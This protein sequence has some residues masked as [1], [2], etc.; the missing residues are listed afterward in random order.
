MGEFTYLG[1]KISNTTHEYVEKNEQLLLS[2]LVVKCTAWRSLPLTPVGSVNLLKMV[3]LPKFLY[4]FH[5][6][7]SQIHRSFFRRLE[8]VLTTFIW[9]GRPPRVAKKILYLPL[10]GGCLA[11]QNFFLYYWAAVLVTVRWWF[12]QP[13]QNSAVIL[14]SYAALTNLVYR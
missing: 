7:A 14:G 6:T 8:G 5:N 12:S 13:R 10:S 2:H 1:I 4:F 11:L 9:A 3:L